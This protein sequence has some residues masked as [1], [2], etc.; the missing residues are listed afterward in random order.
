MN[1]CK[2][3]NRFETIQVNMEPSLILH[4]FSSNR[5]FEYLVSSL[6]DRIMISTI[7]LT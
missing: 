2:S 6:Y 5:L 3:F 4:S 1:T 7:L